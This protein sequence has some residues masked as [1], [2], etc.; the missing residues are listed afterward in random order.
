MDLNTLTW[1]DKVLKTLN[2]H[3]D[4]LPIIQPSLTNYGTNEQILKNVPI[5]AVLGD[6]KR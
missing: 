1:L 2:I 4:S 5:T 3:E 6:A